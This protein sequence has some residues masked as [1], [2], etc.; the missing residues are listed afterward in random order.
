M[1]NIILA[2]LAALS[3]AG[4]GDNQNIES[5]GHTAAASA[6]EVVNP[7]ED[8]A[9]PDPAAAIPAHHYVVE[10]DGEYGYESA[11][12]Q[13]DQI[14]GVLAGK[15][16]MVRF[17]PHPEGMYRLYWRSGPYESLVTCKEPCEFVKLE[18]AVNGYRNAPETQRVVAGTLIW[19]MLQD[20]SAGLVKTYK[21]SAPPVVTAVVPSVPKAIPPDASADQ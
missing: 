16:L 13:A 1:K 20:A 19:A 8:T 11:P 14:N 9:A 5:P 15:I 7:P 3:L 18:S 12:S 17:L 4:C 6:P 2:A 21:P 10:D